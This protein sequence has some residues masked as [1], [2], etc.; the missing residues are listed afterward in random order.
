[1]DGMQRLFLFACEESK[2]GLVL[3]FW[4]ALG[5]LSGGLGTRAGEASWVV[6][7]LF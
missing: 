6:R 2:G 7:A 1:M 5:D 3:G 4:P